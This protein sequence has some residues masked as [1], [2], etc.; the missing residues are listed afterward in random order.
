MRHEHSSHDAR[1]VVGSRLAG[2]KGLLLD[3]DDEDPVRARIPGGSDGC[4]QEP[5]E[6]SQGLHLTRQPEF[7]LAIC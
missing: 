3:R 2:T 7:C 6:S 1:I 5:D 4:F